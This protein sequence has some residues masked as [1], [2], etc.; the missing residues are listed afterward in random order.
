EKGSK[1]PVSI[2]K[3]PEIKEDIVKQPS[4][5]EKEPISE[6]QLP[7]YATDKN[8]D[9]KTPMPI[10]ISSKKKSKEKNQKES[11]IDSKLQEIPIVEVDESRS[12]LIKALDKKNV[13]KIS[14][15]KK[16]INMEEYLDK[17]FT[18]L[19]EKIR[20]R[21]LSLNLPEEQ[22][23]DIV[24]EFINLKEEQQDKYLKELE[25]ITRKINK[26]LIK[27]IMKM[28]LTAAEKQNL[29][30]QIEIMTPEDQVQFVKFL[31]VQK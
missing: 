11:K 28:D 13:E 20:S 8:Q 22:K 12:E 10:P 17:I 25:N 5:K 24:Q 31:E 26:K 18:V 2:D 23:W 6:K 3:E 30:E 27:R 4:V 15:S 16:P 9:S 14:K 19:T 29:I 7:R 21:L 1:K